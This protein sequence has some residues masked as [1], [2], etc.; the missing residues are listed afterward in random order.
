[1]F[2]WLK[3]TNNIE[4]SIGTIEI[5][6]FALLMLIIVMTGICWTLLCFDVNLYR[7]VLK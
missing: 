7:E 1:M 2:K 4:L 3:K 6:N 5:S